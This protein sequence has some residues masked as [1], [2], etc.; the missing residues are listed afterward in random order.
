MYLYTQSVLPADEIRSSVEAAAPSVYRCLSAATIKGAPAASWSTVAR[1][2]NADHFYWWYDAVS[3]NG[4]SDET[5]CHGGN[6][7]WM[8]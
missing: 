6:Q 3:R 1:G 4:V 8:N 5:S 2:G 7:R